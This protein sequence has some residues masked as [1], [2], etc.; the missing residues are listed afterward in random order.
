MPRKWGYL[1]D[2]QDDRDYK[3][4]TFLT[5]AVPKDIPSEM[6]LR[7]LMTPVEDQGSIGSCVANASVGSMEYLHARRMSR[8]W[9]CKRNDPRDYSR[10]FIYWFGREV[11]FNGD[12]Q[13]DTGMSIRGA[14][15]ALKW[16]GVCQEK[17]WPYELSQW[18]IK[19][20]EQAIKRASIRKLKDYYRVE[21][22]SEV[23]KALSRELPVIFG[24]I[25]RESF[26]SD[27]VKRTGMVPKPGEHEDEIGGHAMLA[28]GYD[29]KKNLVL[30]RNSWGTGW[31]IGGHCWIPLELFDVINYANDVQDAWVIRTHP[32]DG[33]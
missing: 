33:L 6:D 10:L 12:P 32:Q 14:L 22:G 18:S 23:L 16:Y 20:D 13:A 21:T 31:G 30:V 25:I 7:K 4:K 19:P 24:Q 17:Y 11:D 28:V 29:L 8:R 9:C 15:K 5:E 27:E 26:M 2:K 3:F 1:P